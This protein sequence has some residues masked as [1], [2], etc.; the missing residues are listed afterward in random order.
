MQNYSKLNK[1][2]TIVEED[3]SDRGN[4]Y[5][6]P[7]FRC[8]VQKVYFVI[9]QFDQ[10]KRDIVTSMGWG[11]TLSIPL[12]SKLSVTHMVW[13]L[14]MVDEVRQAIILGPNKVFKFNESDVEKVFGIPAA[15]I[16]VM[17]KTL[18]RSETVFA[19]K[20]MLGHAIRGRCH[21]QRWLHSKLHTS[22]LDSI[23]L[24]EISMAHD[25]FPRIKVFTADKTR[26]MINADKRPMDS[27][28]NRD[29]I[30][31]SSAP[32]D[33]ASSAYSRADNDYIAQQQGDAWACASK[34]CDSMGL[35]QGGH[36]PGRSGPGPS[37]HLDRPLAVR[38][39]PDRAGQRSSFQ[40][41]D[42][43]GKSPGWTGGPANHSPATRW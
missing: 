21:K 30:F 39:G 26:A 2:P 29:F 5:N 25:V 8:S 24:G 15:G 11:G 1:L 43:R 19:H 18:D 6:G 12:I 35:T 28:K 27:T 37:R 13:L 22:Y 16:D 10:Q 34:I 41:P 3:E 14:G 40:G 20:G 4:R 38:A 36:G 33:A 9:S 32:R 23:N 31:G 7:T 42:R 17:G